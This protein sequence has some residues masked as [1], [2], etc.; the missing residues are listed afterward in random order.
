M[1]YEYRYI[2]TMVP[3][4]LCGE[5]HNAQTQRYDATQC[6]TINTTYIHSESV[7]LSHSELRQSASNKYSVVEMGK[8]INKAR[9]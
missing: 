3:T 7:R 5:K 1:A 8:K 6:D 9:L 2:P 4:I